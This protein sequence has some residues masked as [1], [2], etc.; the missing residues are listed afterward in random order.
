MALTSAQ[1]RPNLAKIPHIPQLWFVGLWQFDVFLAIQYVTTT[2]GNLFTRMLKA[3]WRF[4]PSP[5]L[6][7]IVFAPLSTLSNVP[8]SVSG[9]PLCLFSYPLSR[10]QPRTFLL[11]CCQVST[12]ATNSKPAIHWNIILRVCKTDRNI[13]DLLRIYFW[14]FFLVTCTS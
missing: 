3:Y 5:I 11:P 8:L 13:C 1:K 2:L 4:L 7:S 10:L 12:P 9:P 14:S 6:A